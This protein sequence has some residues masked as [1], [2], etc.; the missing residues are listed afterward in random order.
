MSLMD[1]HG[2]ERRTILLA[3][4][5]GKALSM[6]GD[7]WTIKAASEETGGSLSVI[8]ATFRTQAGPPPHLHRQHEETF[9]VLDGEFTFQVGERTIRAN[10]GTFVFVPRHVAHGFRST[11]TGPGKL[12]ALFTP[13]GYEKYFEELAQLP[14]GP[15]DMN[16]VLPIFHKYDNELV[17][18]PPGR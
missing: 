2:T 11:G 4:G 12:L 17:G 9:Y 15:A 8:E 13:G 3:A 10:P 16:R 6:M 1:N 7:A 18:S 14:P 5:E